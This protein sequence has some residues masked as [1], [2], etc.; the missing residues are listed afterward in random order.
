MNL[1][2][3]SMRQTIELMSVMRSDDLVTFNIIS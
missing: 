1:R 2:E 3:L